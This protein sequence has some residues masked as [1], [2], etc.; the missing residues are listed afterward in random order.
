MPD[1]SLSEAIREAYASAPGRVIYHTLELRH[2]SLTEPIRL[3]LG[4][5]NIEARLE[6]SAPANP[7]EL[8]T[9]IRYYFRFTKPDVSPDGVPTLQVEIENVD[10][11]ITASLIEVARSETPLK[12]TYREFLDSGLNIGPENDPPTHMDIFDA[13]ATLLSV[14]ATA[15]F[16]NLMNRKF[17][18][19]DYD[20]QT[21]PGLVVS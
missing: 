20:A 11:I 17:P 4:N 5:D 1:V 18:T 10:R 3:V 21:W 8:V 16:P 14:T 9:F 2:A 15:G 6:A 13:N 7:G 12:A 19:K